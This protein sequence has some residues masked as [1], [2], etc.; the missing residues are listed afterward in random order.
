MKGVL[1]FFSCFRVR[2]YKLYI[3]TEKFQFKYVYQ[4]LKNIFGIVNSIFKVGR[5]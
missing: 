4:E 3:L 2:Y 1:K 5:R